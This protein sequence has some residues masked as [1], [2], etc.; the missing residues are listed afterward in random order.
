[1]KIGILGCGGMGTTHCLALKALSEKLDIEVVA[2]AD[3]REEFL[4]KAFA[5]WPNARKYALGMDLLHSEELDSVHICLPS[6]LHV[7]HSLEAMARGMNVFIEK[8]VC[9]TEQDCKR[10]LEAKEKCSGKVFV[11]QVVRF[12]DEYAYLKEVY[13]SR[14]LGHLKSIVLQRLSGDVTWGFEDWFHQ[15]EKSGTV[16]LD[17]HVH[18]VDFL[19][20]LLGEPDDVDVAASR[21]SNG[22]V[23]HIITKYRFGDVFATAEGLWDVSPVLPFEASFRAYFEHGTVVYNGRHNPSLV[24]YMEDGTFYEPELSREFETTDNSAGINIS[25]LGPYYTEIKY[26]IESILN[27]KEPSKASLEEGI[28]SVQLALRELALA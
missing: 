27:N 8:P 12:F 3:C 10:L 5:Y 20:Y 1:M 28:K 9:L 13:D 15:E 11:G 16:V 19:R 6:Y 2:L 14:Q 7:E 4:E 22:M 24:V 23:T 17:L 25:T 26:F 21:N 18:D